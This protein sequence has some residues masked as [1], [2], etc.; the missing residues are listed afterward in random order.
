MIL[1]IEE[2]IECQ[3]ALVELFH[4]LVRFRRGA[5]HS[6]PSVHRSRCSFVNCEID[7]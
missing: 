2:H 5:W 1:S 3:R 6:A 7:S 4:S